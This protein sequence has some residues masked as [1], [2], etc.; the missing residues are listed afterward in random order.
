MGCE[1]YERDRIDALQCE[2]IKNSNL[3]N[4]PLGA[5]FFLQ[6]SRDLSSDFVTLLSEWV[7]FQVTVA[8]FSELKQNVTFF[9]KF[10]SDRV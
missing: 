10:T 3:I 1:Q 2:S 6:L 8:L 7:K 4:S 9:G 5:G